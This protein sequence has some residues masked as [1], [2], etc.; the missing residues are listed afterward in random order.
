VSD[1]LHDYAH[2]VMARIIRRRAREDGRKPW[3][4]ASLPG[5]PRL[6]GRIGFSTSWGVCTHLWLTSERRDA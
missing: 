5:L 2:D 4:W 3:S 6:N 1:Y